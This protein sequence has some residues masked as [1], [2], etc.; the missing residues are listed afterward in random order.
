MSEKI[1]VKAIIFD[2]DGVIIDTDTLV[3][4]SIIFGLKEMGIEATEQDVPI[5]AGKSIDALK[6]LLL[7]KWHFDFD[8]FRVIQRKYFYDNLER[9]PYFPET[10]QFIKELHAQG[11]TVALTTSAG[12]EGTMLILEKIGLANVFKVIVA[13]EDCTKFKPDPEP[14]LITAEKLELLPEECVV[15][16][17][18]SVGV[19]AAKAAKMFCIAIP[20]KHTLDQ[21]FSKADSVI[22]S[23]SSIDELISFAE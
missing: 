3:G 15:I 8:A 7:S 19:E 16:E 4:E 5:M 22:D 2:R 23:I 12:K 9:A 10:I 18:S 13:K 6:E 17:D 21:D 14:Y 11:K 20:N 1:S